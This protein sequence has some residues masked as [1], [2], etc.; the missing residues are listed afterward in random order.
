MKT[1]A[2]RRRQLE[3][4]LKELGG[5]LVR[6]EGEL[7]EP[8]P[9]DWEEAAQET[10]GDEV[11]EG[12]GQASEAEAAQI[13]AALERINAGEYGF[14]VTC[15]ERIAEERLDLLPATPFCRRCAR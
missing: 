13:R 10:E 12:L 1:T 8:T 9:S 14:C 7:E 5:R 4:R 6:I 15:G 11:L 2:Q 3:T